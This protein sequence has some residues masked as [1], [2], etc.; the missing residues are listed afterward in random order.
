MAGI[1]AKKGDEVEKQRFF[2][3]LKETTGATTDSF[4]AGLFFLSIGMI[5]R[6]H[7]NYK[8]A[9]QIF[10]EGRNIFMRIRNAAFQHVVQSELGH[11]ARHT[12]DLSEA[13]AIYKE[14]IRSWQDSGN[15]GAVA[16][17]LECF[18]FIAIADEEPQRA[19]KLLGAAEALREKAKSA[20]TDMERIE[21]DQ[22]VAQLRAMLA[23]TEFNALWAD[24]RS[25]TMEEA[26]QLALEADYQ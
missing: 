6:G 26:I 7:G 24:G 10:E 11:V 1:A 23:E 20:M 21:Y 4:Q 3:K 25:M 16:N 12:G 13:K 19:A 18:A 14:T 22:S 8:A 9:Q 17:Q 2:G 15:R 5:E